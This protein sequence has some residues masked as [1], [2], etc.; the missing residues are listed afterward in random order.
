MLLEPGYKFTI[1]Y[2][3]RWDTPHETSY[4][5]T[6]MIDQQG[7]I[8]FSKIVKKHGGRATAAEI[9]DALPKQKAGQ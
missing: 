8:F 4:P 3:L 9:L 7:V 1:L 2:G 5:S 6:F